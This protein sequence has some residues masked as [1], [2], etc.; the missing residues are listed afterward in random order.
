MLTPG[1]PVLTTDPPTFAADAADLTGT[2]D[3]KGLSTTARWEYG[4][5][6]AYG[7][8]TPTRTIAPSAWPM[9]NNERVAGLTPNTTYHVRLV[10]TNA[11]GT[12][13]GPDQVF[14]TAPPLPLVTTGGATSITASSATIAGTV[15]PRGFATRWRVEFGRSS[16][17]AGS[18]PWVDAG[19]AA[20]PLSVSRALTGLDPGATYHYRIAAESAGG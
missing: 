4:L 14:R 10:A 11:S 3:T 20:T 16:G 2:V 15:N 5:T 9:H 12:T 1:P 17:M 19:S 8:S 7:S 13:Y 6:T 18:T